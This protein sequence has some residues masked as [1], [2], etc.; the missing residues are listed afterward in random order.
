[1]LR[2]CGAGMQAS[3]T[4]PNAS[5]SCT[6]ACQGA[7]PAQEYDSLPAG[8]WSFAVTATDAAG[9]SEAGAAAAAPWQV[10]MA[11]FVQIMGGDAGAVISRRA[12]GA[13]ACVSSGI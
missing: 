7:R 3:R 12:A 1:M 10:D 11:A 4:M 13:C 2:M 6:A 5:V 9:N 8:N